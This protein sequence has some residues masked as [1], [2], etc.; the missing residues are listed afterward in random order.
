MTIDRR[1]ARPAISHKVSLFMWR[2]AGKI[3]LVAVGLKIEESV[4]AVAPGIRPCHERGPGDG[5][6]IRYG[7][8]HLKQGPA[9][10]DFGQSRHSAIFDK[11]P[12]ERAGCPIKSDQHSAF[13]R[14]YGLESV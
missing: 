3:D 7:R 9:P 1:P 2:G 14:S 10:D 6:D 12:S 13:L 11:S 5:R 8:V 4:D